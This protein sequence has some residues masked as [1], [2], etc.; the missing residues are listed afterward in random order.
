MSWFRRPLGVGRPLQKSYYSPKGIQPRRS[1]GNNYKTGSTLEASRWKQAAAFQGQI[2]G[3][4]LSYTSLTHA[5]R[6]EQHPTNQKD[7][8]HPSQP[9]TRY[10]LHLHSVLTAAISPL[11][12][13]GCRRVM[14]PDKLGNLTSRTQNR[15]DGAGLLL[16]VDL[17]VVKMTTHYVKDCRYMRCLSC[18]QKSGCIRLVQG[19][20]DVRRPQ[21]RGQLK[22]KSTEAVSRAFNAITLGSTVLLLVIHSQLKM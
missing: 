8:R 1:C 18:Q 14:I 5:L 20:P 4:L 7:P 11:N 6:S 12:L 9:Q 3:R 16:V 15:M 21:G 10:H 2:P 19:K 17:G 13:I 22:K